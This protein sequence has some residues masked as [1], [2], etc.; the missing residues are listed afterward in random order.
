MMMKD[1]SVR[2]VVVISGIRPAGRSVVKD[3]GRSRH[4]LLY[5]WNGEAAFTL[6]NN[7][8]VTV[9][10]GQLAYLPKG[11]EYKMQYTAK[12]TTFVLLNFGLAEQGDVFLA[13]ADTV[14][15]LV[16]QD[17]AHTVANIMA[18]LELCGAAQNTA[19]RLRRKELFYR[20]LSFVYGRCDLDSENI[21]YAPIV[22]GVLLLK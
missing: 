8:T 10:G 6:K 19:G 3:G 22:K 16:K 9:T 2:D 21:A 18:K 14:T 20:L 15:L 7:K 11:L 12:S 5:L 4:G 1:L 17:D 13:A